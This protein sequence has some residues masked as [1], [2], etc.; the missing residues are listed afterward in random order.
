MLNPTAIGSSIPGHQPLCGTFSTP[1]AALSAA[2]PF[3]NW[4][5]T[6]HRIRRRLPLRRHCRS[7]LRS[8]WVSPC[9]GSR[10]RT[11][12]TGCRSWV[13][14]WR[15]ATWT[16]TWSRR[17]SILKPSCPPLI[18]SS[19]SS[20]LRWPPAS[21]PTSPP[22]PSVG[23]PG[24]LKLHIVTLVVPLIVNNLV[25]FFG[26]IILLWRE[27]KLRIYKIYYQCTNHTREIEFL[28]RW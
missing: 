5:I 11:T 6:S 25:A 24:N 1:C 20:M 17:R 3:S 26:I 13:T 9:T 14:G 22:L 7:P 21:L 2:A 28:G 8:R 15:C 19:P 10:G 12:T 18:D 23:V 27:R 4:R 16:S